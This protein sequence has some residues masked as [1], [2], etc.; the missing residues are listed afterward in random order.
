MRHREKR[1][2]AI[3]MQKLNEEK[4]RELMKMQLGDAYVEPQPKRRK[5]AR[6]QK[7]EEEGNKR[8]RSSYKGL[9]EEEKKEKEKERKQIQKQDPEFKEKMRNNSKNWYYKNKQLCYSY[10][11]VSTLK[12]QMKKAEKV[13]QDLRQKCKEEKRAAGINVPDDESIESS[14]SPPPDPGFDYSDGENDES[15]SNAQEKPVKPKKI[16]P[17]RKFIRRVIIQ[18]SGSEENDDSDRDPDF[19]SGASDDSDDDKTDIEEEFKPKRSRGRPGG[20]KTQKDRVPKV[21][22]PRKEKKARKEKEKKEGKISWSNNPE[23]LQYFGIRDTFKDEEMFDFSSKD[24]KC[25][26]CQETFEAAAKL[27]KHKPCYKST[28]C[29][30]CQA[31]FEG[32]QTLSPHLKHHLRDYLPYKCKKCDFK[33]GIISRARYHGL[34]HCEKP[35]YC[36][37]G[38][39]T[40]KACTKEYQYKDGLAVHIRTRHLGQRF[41]CPACSY[42]VPTPER[43]D[44]HM[45]RNHGIETTTEVPA[46][47]DVSESI[48]KLMHLKKV[49]ATRKCKIKF[50]CVDPHCTRRY[51]DRR[52][53]ND[54][55]KKY[56]PQLRHLIPVIPKPSRRIRTQKLRQDGEAEMDEEL[57][58]KMAQEKAG[59]EANSSI[60]KP[61][62][63]M[64]E[65]PV[66]PEPPPIKF[67]SDQEAIEYARQF[68]GAELTEK[69]S[70]IPLLYSADI[71]INNIQ[72]VC[73]YC[74]KVYD[75][76]D[77]LLTHQPCLSRRNG[78]TD[79]HLICPV[80]SRIFNVMPVL[81]RHVGFHHKPFSCK[82]CEFGTPIPKDMIRHVQGV[83]RNFK[84]YFCKWEGCYSPRYMDSEHMMGHVLKDHLKVMPFKCDC[85]MEYSSKDSL[86]FHQRVR[87]KRTEE[88]IIHCD[89]CR[90]Q[91]IHLNNFK[92]HMTRK[93]KNIQDYDF[94][95]KEIQWRKRMEE[96]K[97][98]RSLTLPIIERRKNKPRFQ[99]G[100]EE[101]V[102]T[103][104][105]KPRKPRGSK[106]TMR[107]PSPP[108]RRMTTRA[109]TASAST[110]RH[111]TIYNEDSDPQ[112]FH[113]AYY[114]VNQTPFNNQQHVN[115]TFISYGQNQIV[116][117]QQYT[118][119][120]H[121]FNSFSQNTPG[122]YFDPYGNQAMNFDH[123]QQQIQTASTS[124]GHHGSVPHHNNHHL[125]DQQTHQSQ[126]PGIY[127]NFVTGLTIDG[128][129]IVDSDC[130]NPER[131]REAQIYSPAE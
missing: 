20:S 53:R 58:K 105:K 71:R 4:E 2:L 101:H 52:K 35:F 87:C 81:L 75:R 29:H 70:D 5:N 114:T 66:E 22:K 103:S 17:K 73:Q 99:P 23:V 78:S 122:H 74:S 121:F 21:K 45:K 95:P 106:K 65:V 37:F 36:L 1:R 90:E 7:P 67:N 93:H 61:D 107:S 125:Q 8:K 46:G 12:N 116:P 94:A 44:K 40:D 113:N 41:V 69:E 54:H 57:K 64:V 16:M 68:V 128:S 110:A 47:E 34:S 119:Q 30:I 80:C 14:P 100:D 115:N 15:K 91:F 25:P 89:Y 33:A 13:L 123:F 42:V 92:V 49:E 43:F 124:A 102:P 129:F 83:H 63:F 127:P 72:E 98:Q 9:T 108:V 27:I 130:S 112:Q 24:L 10:C 32:E 88:D 126:F 59:E 82:K 96:R 11:R 131:Q 76:K 77:K 85:G 28:K 60:E 120:G 104:A 55:V 3:E 118:P 51:A 97:K 56:H 109:S 26:K 62:P 86:G 39:E 50:K 117:S 111:T 31:E 48:K 18:D 38:K 6:I 79:G 84:P 19:G